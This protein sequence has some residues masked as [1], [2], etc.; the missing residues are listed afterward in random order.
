MP[1][2]AMRAWLWL[3]TSLPERRV[4][5]ANVKKPMCHEKQADQ[6]TP[7]NPLYHWVLARR[8]QDLGMTDLAEKHFQSKPEPK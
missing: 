8:L 2:S 5:Q 6:F 7:N 3:T 1:C 4:A